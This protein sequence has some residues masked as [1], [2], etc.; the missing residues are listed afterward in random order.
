VPEGKLFTPGFAASRLLD[1]LDRVTPEDSGKV[2]AWDGEIIP[3]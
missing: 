2:F 1:V 3:P